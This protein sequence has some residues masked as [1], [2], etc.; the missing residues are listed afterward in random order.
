M[1]NIMYNKTSQWN[2]KIS[3]IILSVPGVEITQ[4]SINDGR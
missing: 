1:K 2:G 3:D 4:L